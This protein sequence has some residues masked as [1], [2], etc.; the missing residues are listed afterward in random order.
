MYNKRLKFGAI[1]VN[2]IV[3]KSGSS[4]IKSQFFIKWSK[5]DVLKIYYF[6]IQKNH[7]SKQRNNNIHNELFS[8]QCYVSCFERE[9]ESVDLSIRCEIS[10]IDK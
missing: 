8:L 1:T 4:K 6:D 9:I 3:C 10:I 5:E 7:K 2:G